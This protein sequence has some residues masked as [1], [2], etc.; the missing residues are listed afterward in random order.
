VLL[1]FLVL[2]AQFES[3]SLPA[4]VILIVPLCLL[5]VAAGIWVTAGDNNV[6]TRIGF[7]VLIGLA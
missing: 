6:F 7:L 3:W 1:V 5:C 2:P 4:A